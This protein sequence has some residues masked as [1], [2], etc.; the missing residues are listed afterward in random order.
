M[1]Q[2]IS[3]SKHC[4]TEHQFLVL[5]VTSYLEMAL[6]VLKYF[7]IQRLVRLIYFMHHLLLT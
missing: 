1:A 6:S 4:L 5:Y 3:T 7:L 2:S